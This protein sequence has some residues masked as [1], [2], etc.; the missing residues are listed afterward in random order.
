MSYVIHGATGA[1]GAPVAAALAAA[2]TPVT[3]L[4]RN[5]DAVVAGARVRAVDLGAT[6]ALTDAY[7]GA[8]G[9]FVHLPIGAPEDRL[10]H[11]RSVVAAL[12]AARPGRVVFSTSGG[13]PV[14]AADPAVAAVIDGLGRS[15]LSHAVVAPRLFLENLLLPPVVTGAREQG[16]LRYPLPAGHPVSWSSHLDVADAVAALFDRPDVTGLVEV[17]LHP[18]LTGP[19]LAEAFTAHLGHA[20]RY[21]ALAPAAFGGLIAPLLGPGAAAGIAG[22][23]D[24][25]GTLPDNA[26]TPDRSAS[27]VLGL[28]SR[29]VLQ[30]LAD[31]VR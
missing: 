22:L 18:A 26:I 25:L 13:G 12:E 1:Q 9:V 4:T 19:E 8:A 2:G 24:F 17:G 14:A 27:T 7:R 5:A 21:E 23:Y 31:A 29:T 6:E 28:P 15:G 30:W 20:V 11:A 16:V 10:R 3:A